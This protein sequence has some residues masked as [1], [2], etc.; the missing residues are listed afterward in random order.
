[1]SLWVAPFAEP[2]DCTATG[3]HHTATRVPL[4]LDEAEENDMNCASSTY[5]SVAVTTVETRESGN[6]P[7]I[8]K[9]QSLAGLMEKY[10]V[11]GASE[12]PKIEPIESSRR[13]RAPSSSK[14]KVTARRS[15][16]FTQC[17]K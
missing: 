10:L 6:A 5:A 12:I 9:L 2:L 13:L 8:H 1:M 3:V 11:A 7:K 14:L 15:R 17:A 4:Y 16:R